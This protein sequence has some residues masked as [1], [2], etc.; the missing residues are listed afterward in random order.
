MNI[1]NPL[2]SV[3]IPAF[4]AEKYLKDAIESV[5]KQNYQPLEIILIDDGSTDNTAKIAKSFQNIKY[6]YQENSGPAIAR[7]N[8]IK[9]AGGDYIAFLDQDDLWTPNK[10]SLQINYLKDH[11]D[12]SYVLGQQKIFL[13]SGIEKPKWLKQEYLETITPAYLLSA[14]LTRKSI[15]NQIGYFDSSY[16]H[17][18]DSDWLLKTIDARL[19]MYI[20]PEIVLLKRIHDANQSH[21]IEEMKSDVLSFLRASIQRKNKQNNL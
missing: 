19:S 9:I 10:L 6:I 12:I 2:I 15:F 20:I 17:G 7:N 11:S 18:N 8:G 5:I 4:N 16:K 13:E 14:L 1:N 21:N 3:I